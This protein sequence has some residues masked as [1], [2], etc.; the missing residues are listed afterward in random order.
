[1]L[2]RLS[3]CELKSALMWAVTAWSLALVNLSASG[4]R[5]GSRVLIG[6]DDI[7]LV[8]RAGVERFS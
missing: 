7:E 1:M 8:A 2:L 5:N 3:I 6:Q 4:G